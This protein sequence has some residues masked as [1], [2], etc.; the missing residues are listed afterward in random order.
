MRVVRQIDRTDCGP[1]CLATVLQHWGRKEPLYRLRV[2]AGTTQTGTSMW[3]LVRAC[4]Q[5][6]LEVR[7]LEADLE[8][9]QTLE[10]PLMLHWEHNHYVVLV[11]LTPRKAQIADPAIG[12]YW[13]NLA[14]LQEKW[15][16]KLLWLKPGPGFERGNFVGKRGLAGFLAH[17]AHFRGAGAVLLELALATVALSLL[18]LGAPILSQVIFDRVL[19]FREEDLLPYLLAAIFVLSLFQ[20]L[21]TSLRAHLA[22]QLSMRLNYRLKLSYLHHLLRLPLRTLEARLPGDL[23][24]RLGDLSQVESILRNLMVGLP[25]ALLSSVLSFVLLFT[26]NAKLAWVALLVIPIHL[27]HLLWLTPRL[28]ENSRQSLRKGAEVDSFVLGSL[29][30]VAALKALRGEGWALSRGRDQLAGLNDVLW[31]GFILSN[32]GGA[33]VALLGGVFSLFLLWY[34]AGLVLRLELT[35]GQLVAAYGLVQGVAASLSSLSG[36]IVAVQQ[37]TVASDRLAEV[38]ELEPEAERRSAVLRPLERAVRLEHLS[39][40]YLPERPLLKDLC[41]ELPKGSYTAV[42]GPNGG[43]KSTLGALLAQMLLPQSGRIT[44]DGRD[45]AELSPDAVRERVAYLRQEV[46][47]F[48]ATL[49][50]NLS[51]GHNQPEERLWQVLEA[52]GLWGVVRRLPEGL[53]TTIGGES[54]YRFSSGERQLLGLARALLR[55]ADLLILDEPTATLDLDKEHQIV[56][57]LRALKGQRTLLVIT[58]RPALLEPADQVFALQDGALVVLAQKMHEVSG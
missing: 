40:S 24:S 42:V 12:L 18:S 28:R 17:L 14:E 9:L 50:E 21:F 58:H 10:L 27:L 8:G 53:D 36:S 22:T 26:Y 6:G 13:I 20:T 35:V 25:P 32:W 38:I 34:G 51:F 15:T 16:G 48:Y 11:R 5:L 1:A 30:G 47:L 55:P 19:T 57:L 31:Q 44:W 56:A 46:P 7:A 39:F 23:L 45:L 41:L 37:G 33:L 29:E 3:G 52:V 4:K 43:G 2:L 54:I 49:R